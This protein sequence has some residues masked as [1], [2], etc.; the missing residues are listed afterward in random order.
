L[1]DPL[2]Q[3]VDVLEND[4]SPSP[5]EVHDAKNAFAQLK[6]EHPEVVSMCAHKKIDECKTIIQSM[7]E[8]SEAA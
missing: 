6:N 2:V 7:G 8:V 5:D 3:R 1:R 4:L